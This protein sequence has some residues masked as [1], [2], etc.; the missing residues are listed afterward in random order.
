MGCLLKA[1]S[2]VNALCAVSHL[3]LTT[4]QG[5]RYSWAHFAMKMEAQG[6]VIIYLGRVTQLVSENLGLWILNVWRL[7]R[8]GGG[9]GTTTGQR[10]C[11]EGGWVGPG[12]AESGRGAERVRPGGRA[13]LGDTWE[14]AGCL[15][16]M[17][18]GGGET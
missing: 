15:S 18:W 14:L 9:G 13:L 17:G 7:E 2:H 5:S 16:E 4:T 3:T 10:G 6:G 8:R 12:F 11:L 1:S